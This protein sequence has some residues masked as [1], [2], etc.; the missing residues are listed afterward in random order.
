[1]ESGCTIRSLHGTVQDLKLRVGDEL[2]RRHFFYVNESVAAYYETPFAGWD[3]VRD[4]YPSAIVDV[5]EAGK[6][7]ALGRGTACVFHLM[8]VL[9]LGLQSLGKDLGLTKIDSNWQTIINEVNKAIGSLPF[10]TPAEKEYRAQRAEAAAHLQN[11]KDAWRND[12]MHPRATY[13]EEQASEIWFHTRVFMVKL[14][15][16]L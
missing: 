3:N 7:L 1:M 9:E 14:A 5:E 11:I 12:V 2:A 4:K 10:S 13:T 15:E 6:C 8:R 16:L